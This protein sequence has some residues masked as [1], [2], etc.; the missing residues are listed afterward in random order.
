VDFKID[1]QCGKQNIV[2]GGSAGATIVCACGRAISVPSLSTLRLQAGLPPFDPGPV[3]LIQ[4]LLSTGQLPGI[5]SCVACGHE[6]DHVVEVL[7]ECE[8]SYRTESDDRSWGMTL[9]WLFAFWP[10][11]LLMSRRREVTESGRDTFFRLPLPVCKDC[12][13]KLRGRKLVK[14]ALQK[15]PLYCQLLQK[16]PDANVALAAESTVSGKGSRPGEA[17]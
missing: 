12:R 16:F 6:T 10:A 4:H 15:I 14:Q 5:K 7:T 3:M 1:C 2:S 8:T 11:L 13:H 9:F 17:R